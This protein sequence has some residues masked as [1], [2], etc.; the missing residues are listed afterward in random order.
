MKKFLPAFLAYSLFAAAA[1]FAA[2]FFLLPMA[3]VA[4]GS[5]ALYKTTNALCLLFDILPSVLFT[6]F[7]LACSIEFGKSANKAAGRFS[8]EI[9][10][11]FKQIIIASLAIAFIASIGTLIL[12]PFEKTKKKIMQE[13]PPLLAEYTNTAKLYRLQK[14][15][16]TAKQYIKRALALDPNNQEL[17]ELDR[18]IEAEQK[19]AEAMQRAERNKSYVETDFNATSKIVQAFDESKMTI[20]QMLQKSRELFSGKDF[21]GAH[22][23]STQ[24]E[25]LC[26]TDD[27]RILEA[28]QIARDAWTR[29]QEAQ[30]EELSAG[31]IFFRKK[32]QGY[33]NL[34]NGDFEEAYYIFHDLSQEDARKARDPDVLR[35]LEESQKILLKNY[36][37]IDE[38]YDTSRFESANNVFFAIQR[39]NGERDIV[40]IRGVTDVE[41][42]G[43]TLR[44]LRGLSIHSFDEYGKWKSSVS[45]PYAKMRAAA[46]NALT[47][48]QKAQLGLDPSI[49]KLPYVM[50]RSVSRDSRVQKNEPVWKFKKEDDGGQNAGENQL[51]FPIPYEDL[52]L[53]LLSA[54]GNGNLNPFSLNRMARKAP[55]YGY[56]SEVF[57]VESLNRIFY[58][59]ML[60]I[61]FIFVATIAWNYR[62]SAGAIF[63]FKWVFILPSLNAVFYIAEN[64]IKYLIKLLNL[65]FIVMAGT[66]MA[67]LAGICVYIFL[68]VIVSV[69]FLS[70]KND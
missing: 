36:F 57:S 54:A 2:G 32:M 49:N 31:N 62:L 13:I 8:P 65:V 42:T 64:A 29:L 3:P 34:V 60:L 41:G 15:P 59:F 19:E 14:N 48:A 26:K 56:S 28:R 22:Y 50:L 18:K 66:Y 16:D 47:D 46:A 21:F 1:I 39:S 63:K 11:V 17:R 6:S 40:L 23:L 9:G 51:Y 53:I 44:Y 55:D 45:T 38:T 7:L 43:G 4:A 24:A 25:R 33:T 27:P 61:I 69:M 70:R 5:E 68:L 35:Y 10:R 20:A 67:L 37:F 30:M 12:L 58:P 52:S